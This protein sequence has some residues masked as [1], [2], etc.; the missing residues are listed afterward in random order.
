MFYEDVRVARGETVSGLAAAYGYKPSAW[1]LIWNDPR[2]ATV[3]AMRKVPEHLQ[4]GDILQVPI[5]WKVISKTLT[6]QPRGG[7]MVATR[8]GELG[9]RLTWVQTVYQH[10][11]PVPA[12]TPF[13]VDGCPADDN[14]PFYWTNA[15]IAADPSL[16]K[17]FSDYSQR[18]AP[19]AAMGTTK[20]RAVLSLAA[21]TGRRVTVWNSLVWGWDM[22]P[23][24]AI[25]LVGPRAATGPEVTGH[26]HLLRTGQGTG[27]LTFGRAGWT[28]RTPPVE[29]GDFP[30][31]ATT[32]RYA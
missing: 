27:P 28:F 7:L 18:S 25:T 24:N 16:R 1:S 4:I 20:W 31:P 15:E 14:L 10:N 6:M 2:N 12:T 3:V 5:P 8:D 23:A 22:T 17:R 30:L 11:Q 21:V 19:S 29:L 26:L 32:T 9:R 13:C